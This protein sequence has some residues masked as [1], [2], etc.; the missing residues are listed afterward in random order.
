MW[1]N[2]FTLNRRKVFPVAKQLEPEKSK[3]LEMKVDAFESSSVTHLVAVREFFLSK[4]VSRMSR[5]SIEQNDW[6]ISTGSAT[7]FI[8]SC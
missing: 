4:N 1:A 8:F 2:R 5:I 3:H 7:N 6:K